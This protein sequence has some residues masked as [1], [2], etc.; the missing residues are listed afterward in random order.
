MLSMNNVTGTCQTCG[1]QVTEGRATC[2]NV[3]C[4]AGAGR[5]RA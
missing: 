3:V 1:A 2:P 4:M 5:S